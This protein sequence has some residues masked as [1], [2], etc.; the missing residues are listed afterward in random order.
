MPTFSPY[1][2]ACRALGGLALA[3]SLGACKELTSVDASFANTTN[4]ETLYAINGAPVGSPNA[5]K[6]FEGV[7]NRAD[8]G[9]A[10]DV[11]FDI[12]PDGKVEIIP[13]RAV[14]S[15]PSPTQYSVGLQVANGTFESVTEAPKDGYRADTALVVNVGQVVIVESRDNVSVCQFAIKGSSYFT[16]LI[17]TDIDLAKRRIDITF[18]VN[19]NCGFRSFEPGIPKN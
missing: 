13:S 6:F 16:K 15:F 11:V 18:T 9:F 14:A 3:A 19:R 1:R 4:T 5:L 12:T 8:Q 17:V 10:F 7:A 2:F